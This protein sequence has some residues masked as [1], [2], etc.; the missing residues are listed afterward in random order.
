MLVLG[1]ACGAGTEDVDAAITDATIDL[2]ADDAA[3]DAKRTVSGTFTLTLDAGAFAP[4]AAHP[5]ALVYLPSGFDPTPPLSLF[6]YLHG[7]LNCVENIVRDAG[8]SCDPGAGTPVRSASALAAQVEASG[9]NVVLLCP[10]VRFDQASGDPG[11][12]GN[13]GG[14]RALVDEVLRDLSPQLG[15]VSAADVGKL[16]VASHS[17]GYQAAAAIASRGGIPVDELW[18]LD[19]LYGNTAEF[20]AWAMNDVSKLQT[21]PPARRFADVYTQNGGT[22]ANSQAMADR[23]RSWVPTTALADDRTSATWPDST[24]AH[25]LLFKFSA[26][27]H[28]GITRYYVERLLTTSILPSR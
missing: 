8:Q 17:G 10:E 11:A 26:L 5:S 2:G 9:R 23:A 7:H 15:T 19:S 4:T 25:G 20:D 1:S 28:D 14:L 18:L 12:L 21:T 16:V 22:L 24:Y 27:S 6:V 3:P 13:T